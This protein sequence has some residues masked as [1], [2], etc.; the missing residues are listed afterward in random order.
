[1]QL[2]IPKF[3]VREA[4]KRD[5]FRVASFRAKRDEETSW[6]FPPFCLVPSDLGLSAVSHL[7][8]AS[9]LCTISPISRLLF[10]IIASLNAD[11]PSSPDPLSVPDDPSLQLKS[12]FVYVQI[13]PICSVLSLMMNP[14]LVELVKMIGKYGV[15]LD[16]PL[17]PAMITR[18]AIPLS[19]LPT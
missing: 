10:Q 12:P 2:Y 7:L 11:F 19:V 18:S 3:L 4:L 13:A 15:W 8:F 5:W 16:I 14:L 17:R 9:P 1:M 6:Y